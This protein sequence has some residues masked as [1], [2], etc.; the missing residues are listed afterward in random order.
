MRKLIVV[1]IAVILNTAMYSLVSAAFLD[2]PSAPPPSITN[3][4]AA[5][6]SPSTTS[7]IT[8]AATTASSTMNTLSA[9]SGAVN[10]DYNPIVTLLPPIEHKGWKTTAHYEFSGFDGLQDSYNANEQITF[11]IAGSS[12]NLAVEKPNGFNVVVTIFDPSKNVGRRAAV[13][14]DPDKHAWLAR[15]AA[16][17]DS[18]TEYKLVVNLFCEK[19]DSPCADTYGLGTQIDK[20]ITLHVR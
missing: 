13:S 18:T 5:P 1:V 2:I 15:L 19:K 3:M 7:F 8:N 17:T 9:T 14:Y 6:I 11:T 12:S 10:E 4:S 20:I 16:P